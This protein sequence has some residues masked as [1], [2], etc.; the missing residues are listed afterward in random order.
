M[1]AQRKGSQPLAGFDKT[2]E[3]LRWS[4]C[5][6][7]VLHHL[8][9]RSKHQHT[10]PAMVQAHA[11]QAVAVSS[12]ALLTVQVVVVQHQV[13]GGTCTARWNAHVWPV[14]S[15]HCLQLLVLHSIGRAGKRLG[16]RRPD[17]KRAG[18]QTRRMASAQQCCL[19][20]SVSVLVDVGKSMVRTV[21]SS[22]LHSLCTLPRP[23]TAD[24]AQQAPSPLEAYSYIYSN[25]SGHKSLTPL[26]EPSEAHGAGLTSQNS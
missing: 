12:R 18:M 16:S 24:P 26:W 23:Q 22:C 1:Q 21:M 11:Q 8:S 7:A 9:Q 4:Q 5:T 20:S 14:C 17:C 6:C 13:E 10:Q 2:S 15:Q 19:Y 25:W 3:I